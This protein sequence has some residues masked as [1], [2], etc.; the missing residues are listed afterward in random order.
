[1]NRSGLRIALLASLAVWASSVVG[2]QQTE[3]ASP[4]Q[5]M[6]G[7][8][9]EPGIVRGRVQM[10]YGPRL[11]TVDDETGR[12]QEVLVLAPD[13]RATPARGATA[14]AHGLFRRLRDADLDA[15]V[16]QEVDSDARKR[17]VGRTMLVATSLMSAIRGQPAS[18]A[19][20][21]RA[22][23]SPRP[24]QEAPSTTRAGNVPT[25][26][27]PG[28][29]AD[30]IE[31]L[32]GHHVR[33]PYARVVGVFDPR[34][35]LI[36]PSIALPLAIGNRDRVLV[37]VDGGGL[38]VEPAAIV[39]STVT[40][41]GVARTLLGAQ[42]AEEVPWPAQ[43]DRQTAERLE[44]RAAIVATSVQTADG[45]ELTNR[46]RSVGGVSMTK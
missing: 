1:M 14:E 40:I 36:E 33:V 18:R 17:L 24:S 45:V 39:S 43:L 32:A 38:R 28:T 3:R 15:H 25:V 42:V 37:L 16:S 19:A 44:V 20:E 26:V 21:D 31:D 4:R 2:A 27:R 23:Q 9:G 12:R 22:V 46:P 11:F 30:Q 35:F 41:V 8:E 6:P 5:P 29:L 34:A 7:P 13:A 10:V